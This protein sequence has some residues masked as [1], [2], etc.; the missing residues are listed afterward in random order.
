VVEAKGLIIKI[1]GAEFIAAPVLISVDGSNYTK[2]S[3]LTNSLLRLTK[4]YENASPTAKQKALEKLRALSEERSEALNLAVE[5]NPEAVLMVALSKQTKNKLPKEVHQFLEE[6]VGAST[7][8]LSSVI[9]PVLIMCV[10]GAVGF[11]AI[12]MMQPMF[13]IME[14]VK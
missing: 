1:Q 2:L 9:E 4:E 11:F 12:S 14:G 7:Q 3:G 6:E 8:R 5:T 10:G 13:S